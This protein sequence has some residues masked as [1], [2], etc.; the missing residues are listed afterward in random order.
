MDRNDS[1]LIIAAVARAVRLSTRHAWLV[2]PGFLIAAVFAGVYLVRATSP[3]T[4]TA[5]SSCRARSPAPCD[6]RKR[7]STSSSRSGPTGI[8]RWSSA[9]TTAEGAEE[10]AA[11]LAEA[12]APQSGVIRTV[13]R[14]DSGELLRPQRHPV[15]ISRRTCA[16]DMAQL[17]KAE[18]FLGT[19]AADPT[20]H[21]V[22]GAI[23]QSIE[24]VHLGRDDPRRHEAGGD[25]DRR[26]P[27]LRRRPRQASRLFPAPA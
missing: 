19:L 14:P 2:I 15:Q 1:T 20:L 6:S 23:S 27:A 18:P 7:G 11:A 22:L 21:G 26:R 16:G 4:P 3:S 17:I 8:Y 24:G 10:A 13:T 9:T 12:L 25:R 5:A